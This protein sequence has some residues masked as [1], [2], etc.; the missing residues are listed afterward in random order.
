MIRVTL[1]SEWNAFLKHADYARNMLLP[2]VP[3]NLGLA[4]PVQFFRYFSS[5]EVWISLTLSER[6]STWPMTTS[7]MPSTGTLSWR[8]WLPQGPSWRCRFLSWWVG[9]P[10]AVVWLHDPCNVQPFPFPSMNKRRVCSRFSTIMVHWENWYLLILDL[11]LW[12][13]RFRKCCVWYLYT[14]SS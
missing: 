2:V 4:N 14:F 10:P 9:F 7:A 13:I 8:W 12:L 3:R 11:D 1:F 6:I 5:S